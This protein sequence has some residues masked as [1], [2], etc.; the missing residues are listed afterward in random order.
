MRYKD[1]I[2]LVKQALQQPWNYSEAEL[3]YMKVALDKAILGLSR[4]KFEK[5][6]KQGFG[7]DDSTTD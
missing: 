2:R 7:Y 4:K 5:K 3:Q 6:K 1:T